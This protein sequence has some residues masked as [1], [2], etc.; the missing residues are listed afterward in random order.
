L[1]QLRLFKERGPFPPRAGA[2]A[3][4]TEARP[5]PALGRAEAERKPQPYELPA[6][7]YTVRVGAWS[8]LNNLK[9][10]AEQSA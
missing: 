1:T 7:G 4:L 9:E 6:N 2:L 5:Y 3:G 10:L 8:N